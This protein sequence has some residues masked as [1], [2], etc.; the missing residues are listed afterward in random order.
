VQ[1]VDAAVVIEDGFGQRLDLLGPA[2]V[3]RVIGCAAPDLARY[4]GGRLGVDVGDMDLGAVP[5]EQPRGR[6]ANP[7]SG[8]GDDRGLAGQVDVFGHG[9]FSS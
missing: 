3:D 9:D 7:G 2:H 8:A 4:R 6:R 1:D 5:R